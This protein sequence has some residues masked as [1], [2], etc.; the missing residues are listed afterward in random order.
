LK[1]RRHLPAIFLIK[2]NFPEYSTRSVLF[3]FIGM[4]ST[5]TDAQQ[6]LADFM[7][8][9]SEEAYT[10]GWMSNLEY[11]LWEAVLNGPKKYGHY[12]DTLI[13]LSNELS[14]WIYFDQ[15]T[16]SQLLNGGKNI[17]VM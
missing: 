4:E 12:F 8:D 17:A 13:K 3:I 7:S 11:I 6:K 9:I 14:C 2:A 15:D 10:A 16:R 5:L 1:Y